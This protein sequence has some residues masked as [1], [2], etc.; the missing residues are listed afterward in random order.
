MLVY[1]VRNVVN[2]DD[3]RVHVLQ[4]PDLPV[5]Q[6]ALAVPVDFAPRACQGRREGR[7]YSERFTPS[8]PT[9]GTMVAT[10]SGGEKD[11]QQE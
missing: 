1:L 9:R 8:K 7:C 11:D 10:T 2:Q 6:G 3:A 4:G 5:V